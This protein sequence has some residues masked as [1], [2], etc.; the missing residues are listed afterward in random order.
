[1][2]A[3]THACLAFAVQAGWFIKH[4][5]TWGAEGPPPFQRLIIQGLGSP[6]RRYVRTSS[7][8]IVLGLTHD[9]IKRRLVSRLVRLPVC[10]PACLLARRFYVVRGQVEKEYKNE[11]GQVECMTHSS[12]LLFGITDAMLAV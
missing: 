11:K 4:A 9:L 12:G 1:M 10:L 8:G 3:E 2:A 6:T 7:S 5:T